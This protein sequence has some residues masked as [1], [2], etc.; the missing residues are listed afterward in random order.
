MSEKYNTLKR[1]HGKYTTIQRVFKYGCL[2]TIEYTGT[3]S[4]CV[5]EFW[6][7]NNGSRR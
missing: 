3:S 4:H 1:F 6:I 7:M 5:L 2:Y